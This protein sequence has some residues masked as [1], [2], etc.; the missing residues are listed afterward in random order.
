MGLYTPTAT[1]ARRSGVE[2][3]I[4]LLGSFPPRAC[5]IATF[6]AD[7]ATAL[8]QQRSRP[9][10]IIAVDEPG[11]DR[12]YS[13]N[14]HWRLQQHDPQSYLDIAA[15]VGRSNVR[16]VN[17]QH[18]YGLFGGDDGEMLLRFIE[19]VPQPVVTTLHTVVPKPSPH[20]R[21]VT[22]ALVA[23]SSEVVVLA[24]SATPL[25]RDVYGIDP[26]QV[27]YVPHGI[28]SVQ[29]RPG[30]RRAMKL[31]LGLSG[32]TVVSTFGLLNPDK[33]IEYILEALPPLV[34]RYPDLLFLIIGET[35]PGIRKHSGEQYRES[36]QAKV[37]QAGL[38]Q[39][40]RFV[41]KYL[42]LDDLLDYLVATDVYLMAYL[43][44]DQIVSGTLAYAIGCG[45]AVV[46][47]PFRYAQE[48]L[49]GDRG[50][51]VPFRSPEHITTA[52][53]DLLSQP[54]KREAME[55]AA[56]AFSRPMEWHAVAA[57]YGAVF[58]RHIKAPGTAIN[59]AQL[60]STK[61]AHV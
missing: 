17:I 5:G 11:A 52:L 33:G 32:R 4:A 35:H 23:A 20:M 18:E 26:R 51:I 39:H 25:L 21:A 14:V 13:S 45:K 60:P 49:A 1:P 7:V 53:K 42:T 47:T 38:Q 9:T 61:A 54:H 12:V 48:M 15:S 36:L 46:A 40:V 3:Q 50:V 58:Q 6:T 44:P 19:A 16:L 37:E 59:A 57:A 43:N 24:R 10:K 56:W 55:Q 2:A 41:N 22:R 31:R 30:M 8:D 27:A 34:E 28:P 29:R